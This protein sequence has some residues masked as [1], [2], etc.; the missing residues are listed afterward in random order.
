[1]I[2]IV[3]LPLGLLC[4]LCLAV[5]SSASEIQ[6]A[7]PP[8]ISLEALQ[9]IVAKA[10]KTHPR[11]LASMEELEALRRTSDP[12]SLKQSLKDAII[13]QADSLM[14]VSP[15]E[16]KLQGRRLLGQSR[17][18]VQRVI[19][20]SM[21]YHLTGDLKYVERCEKEMIQ[22]AQ[23]K[24]WNPSHFL[25]VAEM[26]FALAIG[27]DWLYN[28][29]EEDS[30]AVIRGAIVQ[31]GVILP[32]ETRHNG[33]VRSS[34]NWGQVCHGGLTAGALAVMEHEPELA[35]KTVHNAL[36][37][38]TRSM[39]AFAPNGS[40]PEGPGYWSYGTTYNVLLIG[41]LESV[42]GLDFGLSKAPGFDKTGQ[43]LNLV[44][45]PSGST[46][47]Y[48]DGG[49]GR[50]SEPAVFWFASRFNRPDW[51]IHEYDLLSNTIARAKSSGRASYGGRFFPFTLLWM[52]EKTDVGKIN[53]P[54]HWLSKGHVP[55]TIHRSS[56]T[57]PHAVF[58][59]LKA[60]SPSANHGQM[61]T[62]SFVMDADGVRWAH[63]LGAEG[64]HGIESRGMNLWD[65]SQ[66][67]DRWKIFRQQNYGHNTLVIDDQ[68]QIAKNAGSI[69]HF[70]DDP[71]FPCSIVDL[72]PVY[73]G[74]AKS[75]QRGVVLLPSNEVLIQDELTGLKP[76]ANVRWGMITRA[77]PGEEGSPTIQLRQDDKS[78]RMTILS[79][80]KSAAWRILD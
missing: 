50:S 16:R 68:L 47:N 9:Q 36:Q 26:T 7:Y 63:D 25:D 35:A 34:N 39:A 4:V 22:A 46:F 65:R 49:A 30:R 19:A 54:L 66:D 57:D 74:Q 13:H 27:Y 23:F 75:V 71:D 78:L 43:Y 15:I 37:N 79:P 70:S 56:W 72:T 76:N 52:G 12:G 17:L 1:M 45:G 3:F 21:A 53:M 41:V 31:K 77:K 64:Y 58:I 8:T 29:L 10:P 5:D 44:T 48:A 80:Q 28:Q 42:L 14:D 61:D 33:W 51:L 59:G 55:I 11:L 38:V 67:S 73:E 69:I 24:D 18:C 32:F 6:N 60:G 20:L 40:Y 2:R 62:G